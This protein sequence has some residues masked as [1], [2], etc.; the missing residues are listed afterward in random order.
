L[1]VDRHRRRV[2][3]RAMPRRTEAV[4]AKARRRYSAKSRCLVG[5]EALK[6]EKSPA[7]IAMACRVHPHAV[8]IGKR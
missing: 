7:Q 2:H 6:G 3:R 4:R 5:R 1:G 8:G